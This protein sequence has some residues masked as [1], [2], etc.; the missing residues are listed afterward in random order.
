MLDDGGTLNEIVG[1]PQ[2]VAPEV[3]AGQPYN[4]QVSAW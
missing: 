3:W 4:K 1:T 2:Y